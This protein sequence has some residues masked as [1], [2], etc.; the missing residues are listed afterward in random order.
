M[1]VFSL[2]VRKNRVNILEVLTIKTYGFR[3]GKGDERIDELLS[4][5]SASRRSRYIKDAVLFFSDVGEEMK[6]LSAR[7]DQALA[8]NPMR[9]QDNLSN[10]TVVNDDKRIKDLEDRVFASMESVLGLDN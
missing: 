9:I 6:S 2:T 3:T 10:T 5:M 7:V 4:S 1:L 8:G